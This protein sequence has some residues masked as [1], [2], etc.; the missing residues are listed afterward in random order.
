MTASRFLHPRVAAIPGAL[1]ALLTLLMLSACSSTAG[2]EANVPTTQPIIVPSATAT[3]APTAT[4]TPPSCGSQF[5]TAFQ[6]TI[7]DATYSQTTVYAEVPLPPETRSFDDD[8]TGLRV[9]NM[10][11]AGTTATVESFMTTHLTQLGWTTVTPLTT[12]GRADISQ[13]GDPQC[14]KSGKY[15]LFVGVNSN[16]DWLVAYIDPGFLT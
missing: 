7:P 16:T 14:W 1:L 12:C 5:G 10:C 6:A 3:S 13:Y 11:S 9:R 15:L 4:L 2:S 8:A